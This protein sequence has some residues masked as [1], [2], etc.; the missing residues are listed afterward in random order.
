MNAVVTG[1]ARGI[2]LGIYNYLVDNGYTVVSIGRSFRNH[3]VFDLTQRHDNIID[4]ECGVLINNA[5]F[6]YISPAIDYPMDEWN[7]QLEMLTA[8]FDLSR[9]AYNHGCKRIIN[10]ASTA[11]M[12]GTKGIIGYSVAKAGIIQMTK[13]L[14]N[15]W[16]G[17]CTVNAIA[18]GYI[19]TDILQFSEGQREQV[20]S[21]IPMKRIGKVDDIIPAV[22]YLLKAEYVTGSVIT[23]DG[24]WSVR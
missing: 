20:E 19:D 17:K 12:Q 21:Y 8:Y 9:Q 4:Y 22:E 11:G 1:G 5:G 6:Q 15:E 2:G 14:A 3:V 23:V 10:I 24:G 7:K 13:C 18:P 16:A